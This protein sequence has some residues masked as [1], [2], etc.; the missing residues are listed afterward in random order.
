M[1][2]PQGGGGGSRFLPRPSGRGRPRPQYPPPMPA[3]HRHGIPSFIPQPHY[4]SDKSSFR[5]ILLETIYNRFNPE[6]TLC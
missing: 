5:S 1:R 3:H 6:L 2:R 4:G